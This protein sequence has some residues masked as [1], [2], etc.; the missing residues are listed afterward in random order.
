MQ[1]C[2]MTTYKNSIIKLSYRDM[3]SLAIDFDHVCSTRYEFYPK[4]PASPPIKTI[5][6]SINILVPVLLIETSCL[7]GQYHST[8]YLAL[9]KITETDKLNFSSTKA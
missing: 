6:N 1:F 2:N 5:V 7:A 4:E 3:A 8:Q 9:E